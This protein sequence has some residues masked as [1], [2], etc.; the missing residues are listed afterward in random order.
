MVFELKKNIAF[1]SWSLFKNCPRHQKII[2]FNFFNR[3]H[4]AWYL[5]SIFRSSSALAF[6]FLPTCL[7]FQN[8]L[9]LWNDQINF[10]FICY[11]W[12]DLFYNIPLCNESLY[13]SCSFPNFKFCFSMIAFASATVF[14]EIRNNSSICAF[15]DP[16]FLYCLFELSDFLEIDTESFVF[17]IVHFW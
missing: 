7:A 5:I 17:D 15:S 6:V 14:P 2:E 9:D 1:L 10:C 12:L 4:F 16:I 13:S 11:Q 3:D 8:Y